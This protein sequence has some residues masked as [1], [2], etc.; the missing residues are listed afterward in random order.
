LKGA[1][2]LGRGQ[3]AGAMID[4]NGDGA[5]DLIAA[6]PTGAVWALL[7]ETDEAQRLGVTVMPP[8]RAAGPVTVTVGGKGR[9]EGM[10]VVRPGMPA[11]IGRARRGPVDLTFRTRDGRT[12]T[13]RVV[14]L[15]PTQV[16]LAVPEAEAAVPR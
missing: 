11:F 3:S 1:A 14:V 12:H 2:A 10:Y 5:Q 15:R 13:R 4:L 9:C 16:T 6:A 7:G 8:A